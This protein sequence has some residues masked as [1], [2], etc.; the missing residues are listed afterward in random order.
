[1]IKWYLKIY[2]QGLQIRFDNKIGKIYILPV[3]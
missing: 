1:M 2:F 3:K